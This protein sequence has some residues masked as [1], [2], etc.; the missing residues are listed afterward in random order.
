LGHPG[1][2]AVVSVLLLAATLVRPAENS[3]LPVATANDNR[4]AAGKINNKKFELHLEIREATWYPEDEGGG[5]RDVYAFAEA[6]HQPQISGPLIRVPEGTEIQAFLRNVLPIEVKVYGL[7]SHPGDAQESVM[8]AAGETRELKFVA[9]EAG[10]YLYWATTSGKPIKDRKGP[11]TTLSGAFVVDPRGTNAHDEVFVVGLWSDAAFSQQ[12]AWI[13]GKSWPFTS[14]L[15]FTVGENIRWRVINASFEPHAMHLHGFFFTVAGVG[16]GEHYQQFSDNQKRQAVTEQIDPGHTFEMT[17][18]PERAGNWLFH[19]HMLV[20]MSVP[21]ALHPKEAKPVAHEME[22]SGSAGMGGLV[23]GV[24]VLPR[25]MSAPTSAVA[26]TTAPRKLQLLISENPDKIPLYQ[27]ELNDPTSSA[28]SSKK[29]APRLLGPPIVLTRGEQTEIEVKNLTT[30]PTAIH[31]HGIELESFYDGVPGWTG[32]G[33]QTT[34]AIA[35]GASFVARMTPPRAGTFIYHTHWHDDLQL[36]NGLYGPLI[37]LEPGQTFDPEHDKVFVFSTGRYAPLGLMMLVNGVPEPDPVEL[38]TG[39]RYRLRFINIT[40]NESDLRVSFTSDELP[41]QW[42]LLARDG[43]D[44][45]QLS[46]TFS[47]ANLALTVGSTCDVEYQSDREGYAEM[48][49]S[50]RSFEGLIMQPFN[51]VAGK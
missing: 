3:S 37:V 2:F 41:V 7:H 30:N 20:H 22:Q 35:P 4:T 29:H 39:T 33:Q 14:H 21:E 34:P 49:V 25:E 26:I 42:K 32:S 48:Q 11:E 17:W 46:R 51:F 47:A 40:T 23:I 8:L 28:E 10:T 24:T 19:C 15:S 45:P 5:H 9:G 27:L 13:N 50:A 36:M 6:G 12:I 1:R 31:W 38:K 44:F 43:A 18:V 16:D